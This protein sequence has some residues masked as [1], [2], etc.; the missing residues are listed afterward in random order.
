MTR[1]GLWQANGLKG[2]SFLSLFLDLEGI[3]RTGQRHPYGNANTDAHADAAH[4]GTNC[5]ADG[6]A[7]S[8]P[9]AP[10][11]FVTCVC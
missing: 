9:N 2:K 10:D 1:S 3:H 6:D 5:H 8:Y 11:H 7:G 4:D